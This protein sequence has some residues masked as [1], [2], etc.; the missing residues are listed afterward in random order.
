MRRPIRF[1]LLALVACLAIALAAD[2]GA[3]RQAIRSGEPRV[4]VR[5]PPAEAVEIG[6]RRETAPQPPPS[7]PFSVS[8]E[9]RGRW[10]TLFQIDVTPSEAAGIPP[11]PSESQ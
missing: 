4:E 5:L 2:C 11:E 10:L 1:L 3:P 8:D 7:P 9:S 6:I